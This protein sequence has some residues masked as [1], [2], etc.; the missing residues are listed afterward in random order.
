MKANPSIDA[1]YIFIK[2]P[3]VEALEARLRGRGTENEE[4]IQQ[5]LVQAKVKLEYAD[6]QGNHDKII[7]DDSIEKAYQELDEFVFRLA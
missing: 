6:S 5:R 3:R 7:V 4:D 1:R 2:P